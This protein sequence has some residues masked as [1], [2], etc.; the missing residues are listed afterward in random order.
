[1]KKRSKRKRRGTQ[2][3][4][5]GEGRGRRGGKGRKEEERKERRETFLAKQHN[6]PYLYIIHL[7]ILINWGV[8][9]DLTFSLYPSND[10]KKCHGF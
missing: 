7:I 5:G 8:L 1:M 6:W 10:L 9:V 3:S 4:G 2:K